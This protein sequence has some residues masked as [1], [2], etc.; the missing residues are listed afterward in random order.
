MKIIEHMAEAGPY[1]Y[2]TECGLSSSLEQ[3]GLEAW[4]CLC[5]D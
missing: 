1:V 4:C 2:C 3:L 5:L